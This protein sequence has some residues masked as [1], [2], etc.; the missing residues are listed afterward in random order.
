MKIF[1]RALTALIIAGVSLL[2]IPAAFAHHSNAG[3]SMDTIK[4]ITGT[5]KEFQ[6]RNPH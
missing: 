1:H 6:F 4:E 2:M 3:F 5:V